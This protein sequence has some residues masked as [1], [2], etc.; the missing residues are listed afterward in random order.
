MRWQVISHPPPGS[1]AWTSPPP[2]DSVSFTFAKC[3]SPMNGKCEGPKNCH[4]RL[5]DKLRDA[6]AERAHEV[7]PWGAIPI[8]D[9]HLQPSRQSHNLYQNNKPEQWTQPSIKNKVDKLPQNGK[10][11]VMDLSYILL[12]WVIK[13]CKSL[14]PYLE[15]PQS[16]WNG[17]SR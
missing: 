14:C 4:H 17:G 8:P 2:W 13:A 11:S 10:V 12:N 5:F 15:I 16:F 7:V 1:S 3:C 6:E 9:L